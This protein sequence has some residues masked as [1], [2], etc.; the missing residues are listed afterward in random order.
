MV[1]VLVDIVLVDVLVLVMVLVMVMVVVMVVMMAVVD[2]DCSVQIFRSFFP[3]EKQ[4]KVPTR[5]RQAE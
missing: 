2:V 4:K 3:S 1:V 5:F